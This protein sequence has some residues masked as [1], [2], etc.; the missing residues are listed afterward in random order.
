MLFL[1]LQHREGLVVPIGESIINKLWEYMDTLRE[2]DFQR[3]NLIQN[4]MQRK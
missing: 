3:K 2:K 4:L 1:N